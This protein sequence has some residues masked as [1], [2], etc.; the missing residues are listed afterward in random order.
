MRNRWQNSWLWL[1]LVPLLVGLA[2]IPAAQGQPQLDRFLDRSWGDYSWGAYGGSREYS[3]MGREDLVA[4]E[5][6]CPT[7]GCVLRLEG[8]EVRPAR[9]RKGGRVTL[10]ATYTILTPEQVAIPIIIS[11][12]IMFQGKSLGRTKSMDTRQY[13]GS[14]TQDVEFT[15]PAD[16]TPGDYTMR[17][18]V[19]TGYDRQ[20]KDVQF[21]V[22]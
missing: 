2:G 13:N 15:L 17:T 1:A 10:G 9:A 7:G 3:R 4:R 22:Y 14:W 18:R 19:S 5:N 20:E 11:R 6:Y 21:Q 8:V 16:A 12:E